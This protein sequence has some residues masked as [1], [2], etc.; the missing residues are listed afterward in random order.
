MVLGSLFGNFILLFVIL[1]TLALGLDGVFANAE[2]L[3]R[4]FNLTFTV[5]FTIEMCLKL[6]GLG[7]KS[8]IAS[9]YRPDLN[10]I[11]YVMDLMNIFDGFIVII[12]LVEEIFLDNNGTSAISAFRTVRIFRTFRVLR[13]TKLLRALEYMKIVIRVIGR[14][15]EKFIYIA[16]LLLI[17]IFIYTL[18]GM[19]VFGDKF[20]FE[21]KSVRQNFDSFFQGFLSVFQIMTMENWQQLLYLALRSEVNNLI[22]SIYFISWIFI[23]NYI[24]LNLFLAILLDEFSSDETKADLDET[25]KELAREF[26]DEEKAAVGAYNASEYGVESS[27]SQNFGVSKAGG[28]TYRQSSMAYGG[29]SSARLK[30]SITS[31]SVSESL[32]QDFDE[33]SYSKVANTEENLW[34][35][36]KCEH[37]FYIFSK[38]YPLRYWAMKITRS[39]H[40]ENSILAAIMISSLKLAIETYFTNTNNTASKIMDAIDFGFNI[41]FAIESIIKATALGLAFDDGSYLRESWNV[42]D[43]FIVMASIIDMSLAQVEI[44]AIRVLVLDLPL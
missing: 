3:F 31:R 22:A 34:K 16:L 7:P 1:N 9:T 21:D 43:F 26:E 5:V 8:N 41:F 44:P 28:S 17:M 30:S 33:S 19:Q 25:E 14:S 10:P 15:L 42:L 4:N 24:F 36:I 18:L 11:A 27:S 20:N 39:N 6:I 38:T 13:V 40:F 29:Q 2:N 37:S 23:G 12:S 35:G 32:F